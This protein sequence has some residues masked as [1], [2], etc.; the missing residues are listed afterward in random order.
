MMMVRMTMM[1]TTMVGMMMSTIVR[2]VASVRGHSAEGQ[3]LYVESP[4]GGGERATRNHSAS[5]R[6]HMPKH[7]IVLREQW[8]SSK[9]GQSAN[10]TWTKTH[11]SNP[12]LRQRCFSSLQP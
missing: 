9:Q 11:N 1:I 8:P 6:T 10:L 5:S 7:Q 3:V 4:G 2:V 12:A